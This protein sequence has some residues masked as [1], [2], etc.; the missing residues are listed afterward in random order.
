MSA[1][2]TR[3]YNWVNDKNNSIKI[4]ASRMDAEFDQI[5]AALNQKAVIKATAPDSPINGMIW[6]DSTNSLLKIYVGTSWS[7]ID[8]MGKGADVASAA[9]T[10][11]GDDGSFFDITGTTTITSITAKA[12]GKIVYLQFDGVLTV[13]DGSNLKLDGNFV[14]AAG[15]VLTLISDGTN[16]WEVARSPN[17]YTPT[18]ANALAGSIVQVVNSQ[19]GEVV[20]GS[21]G[22][23]LDDTIPQSNEGAEMFTCAI[24]PKNAS[25]LLIILA[26]MNIGMDTDVITRVAL[27]HGDNSPTH[28]ADCIAVGTGATGQMVTVPLVYKMTAGTTSAITF[29][30]RIGNTNGSQETLNGISGARRWG[31]VFKS[32]ITI[33][34]VKV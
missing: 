20:T 2:I 1:P 7:I 4:T 31:G 11:L 17:T 5:V 6:Y 16:W 27:F 15:S 9:T 34:E 19:D 8:F 32:S 14:T 29:S 12:A 13:T 10:T 21:V 22:I 24:T 3:L 25:N 18:A 33:L 28:D 23:P 26:N 30:V